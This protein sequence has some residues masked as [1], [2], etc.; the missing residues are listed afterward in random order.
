MITHTLKALGVTE[1]QIMAKFAVPAN[2]FAEF[3]NNLVSLLPADFKTR[4]I[5]VF[6]EYQWNIADEQDR[7]FLQFPKNMKGGGFLCPAQPG[8]W[9][10][11][12]IDGALSYVNQN[13]LKHPFTRDK[14][15]MESNKA[16]QQFAG[17]N[18]EDKLR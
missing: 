13:G 1:E 7:T 2:S 8:V 5:D 10:E 12:R 14:N 15:Y 3:A 4:P 9:K 17:G 18:L 6:L 11:E 16:I